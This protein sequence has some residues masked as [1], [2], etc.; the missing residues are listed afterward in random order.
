MTRA[1][2]VSLSSSLSQGP[3]ILRGSSV[4]PK[5]QT[6][7]WG[8]HSLCGSAKS[9]GPPV[10]KGTAASLSTSWPLRSR[11]RHAWG[12]DLGQLCAIGLEAEAWVR[13]PSCGLQR[14]PGCSL[15]SHP[16]AYS[17][18]P[19]QDANCK[20]AVPPLG[21]VVISRFQGSQ[22]TRGH[23][24]PRTPRFSTL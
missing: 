3:Q 18:S 10:G 2:P 9:H 13:G 6:H 16:A 4:Y 1:L 17:P 15:R 20:E 5:G 14:G 12:K 19:L 23:L 22:G 21:G 7:S 11:W 24:S 8:S